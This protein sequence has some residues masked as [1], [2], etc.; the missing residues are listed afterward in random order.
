MRPFS[1]KK[2]CFCWYFPLCLRCVWDSWLF[3]PLLTCVSRQYWM[4]VWWPCTLT[5]NNRGWIWQNRTKATCFRLNSQARWR[6]SRCANKADVSHWLEVTSVSIGWPVCSFVTPTQ[7]SCRP[8][9][10]G[11]WIT[12]RETLKKNQNKLVDWRSVAG[13]HDVV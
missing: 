1:V 11:C 12:W 10:W 7:V 6:L 3:F 5:V 2:F 9:R 8:N 4:E 13:F